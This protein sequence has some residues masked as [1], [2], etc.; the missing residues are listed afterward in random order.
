MED[1]HIYK[2]MDRIRYV[3]YWEKQLKELDKAMRTVSA[4]NLH[5]F[6]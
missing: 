4:T 3:Q 5:G 2:A 1:A 6:R